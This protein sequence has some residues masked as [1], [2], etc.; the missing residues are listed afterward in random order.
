MPIF[1]REWIR[2]GNILT[3]SFSVHLLIGIILRHVTSCLLFLKGLIH[4]EKVE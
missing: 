3:V 1:H 4:I 2:S